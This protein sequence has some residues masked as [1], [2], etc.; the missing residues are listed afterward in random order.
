LLKHSFRKIEEF[1][2][3]RIQ[4]HVYLCDSTARFSFGSYVV[5]LWQ[6]VFCKPAVGACAAIDFLKLGI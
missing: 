5:R 4:K 6:Y 1:L 3:D 2:L